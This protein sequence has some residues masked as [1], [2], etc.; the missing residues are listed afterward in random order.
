MN[1]NVPECFEKKFEGL[2]RAI[3][4]SKDLRLLAHYDADGVSSAAIFF[5]TLKNRR[6][7]VSFI[8]DISRENVKR[9]LDEGREFYIFLDMGASLISLIEESAN[10]AVLDHHPP[11]KESDKIIHINPHFC[12]IS[13][14][15]DACGA[16]LAYLFSIY[17]DEK[18]LH[19]YPLFFSGVIGDRQ[20][21]GGYSGLNAEIVEMLKSKNILPR[22]TLRMQGKNI[23]ESLTYSTEP[24]LEGYSGR[25]EIVSSFLKSA[26]MDPSSTFESLDEEKRIRLSSWIALQLLKRNVEREIIES[27]VVDSFSFDKVKDFSFSGNDYL[28]SDMVDACARREKQ[29]LALAYLSGDISREQEIYQNYIE[30]RKKLIEEIYRAIKEK[31]ELQNIQYFYVTE[32]SMAGAV[33]GTLM[34]Y[35]LDRGKVTLALHEKNGEVRISGRAT[36][37]LVSK[38]ID[39]GKSMAGCAEMVNGYGGGHDIAAGANVPRDGVNEF[40]KCVDAKIG[41]KINDT[42]VTSKI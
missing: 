27:I 8:K 23:E 15:R 24:F 3:E 36:R 37:Y 14:S 10:G 18:N 26:G 22:I 31:K 5:R 16:T 28:L 21:V 38:G 32:D 25:Q 2:K 13:G 17:I 29:G 34:M 19:M 42:K 6:L 7:H 30:H 4:E 1:M 9:F 39:L 11:E 20:D 33:S 40:L 12:G 35:Y 41:E